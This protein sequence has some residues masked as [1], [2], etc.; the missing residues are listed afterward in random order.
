M[1]GKSL[2]IL[3]ILVDSLPRATQPSGE[4]TFEVAKPC[5]NSWK[6]IMSQDHLAQIRMILC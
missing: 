4:M 5:G 2:P 6:E 3:V 1:S